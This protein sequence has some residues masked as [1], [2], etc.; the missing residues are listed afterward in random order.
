MSKALGMI[1]VKGFVTLFEA[2]DAALKSADVTMLGWEKAGS[3]LVSAYFSGDVASVKA[4]V[5]AA[6]GA[7]AR[8]GKVMAV[9]VIAR[10]HDDLAKLGKFLNA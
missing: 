1:E 9:Q 2:C 3:G 8:I 4:A 6:A 10:P 5:D 7:A